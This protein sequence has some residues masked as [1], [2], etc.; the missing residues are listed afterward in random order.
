MLSFERAGC[1]HVSVAHDK[2]GGFGELTTA[3]GT[4][5]LRQPH[6]GQ[7]SSQAAT[8]GSVEVG[9]RMRA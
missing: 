6:D 4:E 8:E 5:Q 7:S 1:R 2:G 3:A 9:G